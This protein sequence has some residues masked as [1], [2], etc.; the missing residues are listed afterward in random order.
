MGRGKSDRPVFDIVDTIHLGVADTV[1]L[2]LECFRRT[3]DGAVVG[4]VGFPAVL[5]IAGAQENGA[6]GCTKHVR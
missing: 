1:C 4:G 6:C 3:P 5:A 2:V